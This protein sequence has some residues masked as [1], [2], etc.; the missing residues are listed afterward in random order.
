MAIEKNKLH[1]DHLISIYNFKIIKVD[2]K[3]GAS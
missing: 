1:E 3:I 2:E